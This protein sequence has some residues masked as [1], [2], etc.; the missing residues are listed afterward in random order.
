MTT[1]SKD[2]D[3]CI[4]ELKKLHGLPPY[5]CPSNYCYGDGFFASSIVLE[6]DKLTYETATQEILNIIKM[7]KL[8]PVIVDKLEETSSKLADLYPAYFKDVSGLTEIDVYMT[9]QLF[10]IQDPSGCIHHS[11]KKLLLSGTRTG[12]KSKYKD[13]KE[14]RDTLTRWLEINKD[15]KDKE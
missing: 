2:L 8:K 1:K 11:S 9:H 13:I 12:G 4:D 15:L 5:N 10:N 14:A 7:D 6:F 3:K